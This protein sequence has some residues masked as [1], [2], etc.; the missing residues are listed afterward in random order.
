MHYFLKRCGFQELGSVG[1][2]GKAKRGRYLMTSNNEEVVNFFP[3]LSI[4]IANDTAVLPIVPLYNRMKTYC[5]FVYHNSKYT[6]TEAK[7]PR[8]E[9]R[10]YLNSEIEN[11]QL[12]FT[13][14]DILVMRK[15]DSYTICS[16]GEEQEFYYVDLVKDHS[17]GLY[18]RLSRIIELYPIAGGYGIYDGELEFF[19]K[20]VKDFEEKQ[21]LTDVVID[22]SVMDRIS[23]ASEEN[24][25]NVFNPATFRDFVLAGYCNACAITGQIADGII[26]SG[27]DVVYIRPRSKGG[28]SNPSNGIALSK[29]LSLAFIQG[30]YTLSD[31][32]EVLVHPENDDPYIQQYHLKQIRIPP[33][34]FFM[35]DKSNICFHRENIYGLFKRM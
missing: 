21:V 35:P 30:K 17:S 4:E 23:K 14:E 8:N 19:E 11:H 2:D 31:N 12:Y 1:D 29:D 10:I 15:R 16:D 28:D 22:E 24:R 9:R 33:N 26:G 20:Q 27:V 3:P 32:C 18:T 34:K 13:A 25:A 6:G 7:H 5:S